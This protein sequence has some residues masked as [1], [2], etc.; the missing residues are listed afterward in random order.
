VRP[1]AQ[2]AA[3][4]LLYLV[5]AEREPSLRMDEML[6][7]AGG[8]RQGLYPLPPWV[9]MIQLASWDLRAARRRV[10]ALWRRFSSVRVLFGLMRRFAMAVW[11]EHLHVE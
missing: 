4:D 11:R 6:A 9:S 3:E 10:D 7:D 8:C 1:V 5:L 2:M